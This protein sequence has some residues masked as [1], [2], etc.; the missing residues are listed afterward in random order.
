MN[1]RGRPTNEMGDYMC[2]LV[3]CV[4]ESRY[5]LEIGMIIMCSVAYVLCERTFTLS[6]ID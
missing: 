2:M 1:R 4:W 6:T 5:R 3:F